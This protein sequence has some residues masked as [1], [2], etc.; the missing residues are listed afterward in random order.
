VLK[1]ILLLALKVTTPGEMAC[2]GYTQDEMLPMDL[3]IAGIQKEGASTMAVQGEIVYLNGRKVSSLKVGE[4]VQIIRPEGKVRDPLTGTE[5]AI[6]YKRLGTIQIERIARETA[7]ARV[8]FSCHGISKGD[9]ALPDLPRPVVEFSGEISSQM[10]SIPENGFASSIVLGANDARELAAGQFCFIAAGARDNIKP[11]D[12]FTVVRP[13][14]RYNPKDRHFE[15]KV[16][17]TSYPSAKSWGDMLRED[18]MLHNRMLPLQIL[19]DIV[20]VEIGNKVS[21]AKVINSIHEIHVG[22]L[23]VK[24]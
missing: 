19:G 5:L 16:S 13:Y 3:Y 24:R 12:R 18:A 11:G 22:D 2:L 15:D 23:V 10:T 20:V 14:S 6:Y 21:A 4:K 8:L 17:D 7:T 9:L 1:L